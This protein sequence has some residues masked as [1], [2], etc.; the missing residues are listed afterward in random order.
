M[1]VFD[2]VGVLVG[3]KC[4]LKMGGKYINWVGNGV[5]DSVGVFVSVGV[6][7]GVNVMVGEGVSVSENGK[8][9]VVSSVGA[10]E[11]GVIIS[12]I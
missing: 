8:V 2:G 5:G 10:V 6:K 3:I 12:S 1:G 7:A 11:F 9:K 4:S